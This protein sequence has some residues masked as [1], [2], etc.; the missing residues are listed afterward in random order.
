MNKKHQLI[1]DMNL[2]KMSNIIEFKYSL[3]KILVNSNI[4]V[5]KWMDTKRKSNHL[6]ELNSKPLKTILYIKESNKNPG[7][8][9]L[10]KNHI[11]TFRKSSIRWF[12]VLLHNS[13][14]GGYLISGGQVEIRIN[15]GK[16]EL[17]VDGDYKVN[18]RQDLEK[19]RK[20][21]N[22]QELVDRII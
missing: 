22:I 20:F 11:N 18:E 8:W 16:F 12:V 17:S 3:E 1:Y 2:R 14:S 15:N 4:T 13:S 5:E 19:G 6:L 21:K 10:T 9:G 7:F